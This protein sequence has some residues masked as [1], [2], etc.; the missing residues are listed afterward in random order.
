MIDACRRERLPVP[1][2][3]VAVVGPVSIRLHLS[4]PA[5]ESPAP[6]V[7]AR[8]GTEWSRTLGG[9]DGSIGA[10]DMPFGGL[11]GIGGSTERRFVD[12]RQA[13]GL[14]SIEG[15]AEP[16]VRRWIDELAHNPWSTGAPIVLV[17]LDE[18]AGSATV[19]TA[20]IEDV[21]AGVAAGATGF[22]VLAEH[23]S[24]EL[25]AELLRALEHPDCRWP[26][27]LLGGSPRARWRFTVGADGTVG[28]DALLQHPIGAAA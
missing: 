25:G 5:P 21:V 10:P 6:W 12:L 20:T 4:S 1:G 9:L 22:A 14:I 7:A 19:S 3:V 13:H 11:I 24:G 26:V 8:G 18:L 23:P 2:V 16:T 28:N 15:E 17:G 27:I